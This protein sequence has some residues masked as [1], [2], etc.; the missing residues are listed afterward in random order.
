MRL[1]AGEHD[2][3]RHLPR[4]LPLAHSVMSQSGETSEHHGVLTRILTS[5]QLP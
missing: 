1:N 3:L 2:L 5:H 4:H